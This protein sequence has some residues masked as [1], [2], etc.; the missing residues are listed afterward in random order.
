MV[1]LCPASSRVMFLFLAAASL[2]NSESDLSILPKFI[3]TEPSI[4]S[5]AP[6]FG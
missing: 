4:P 5:G 6:P 1:D 3:A 2:F